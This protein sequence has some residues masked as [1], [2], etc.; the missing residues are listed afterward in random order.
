MRYLFGFLSF[1][2]ASLLILWLFEQESFDLME[3]IPKT[4]AIGVLMVIIMYKSKNEKA[5]L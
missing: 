3:S 1:C 4:M 2:V 5:K